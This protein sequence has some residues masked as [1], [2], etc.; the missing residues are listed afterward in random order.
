MHFSRETSPFEEPNNRNICYNTEYP[1]L[2]AIT[3]STI[4]IIKKDYCTY[5]PK[6]AM[7]SV[8][9]DARQSIS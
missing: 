6:K 1:V 7:Q 5:L 8:T 2:I 4:S 3:D 9:F